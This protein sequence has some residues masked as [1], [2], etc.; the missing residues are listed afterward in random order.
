MI[1]EIQA[2]C[3]LRVLCVDV[4]AWVMCGL[5]AVFGFARKG[6]GF[7]LPGATDPAEYY[8]RHAAATGFAFTL[9]KQA[10]RHMRRPAIDA[11]AGA[12]NSALFGKQSA[13]PC[14]SDP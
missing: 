1:T 7:G 6:S 14:R 4:S 12:G 13:A 10:D 2:A 5:I 3:L 9:A 8:C 11:I